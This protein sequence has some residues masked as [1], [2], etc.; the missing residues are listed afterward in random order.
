M[1]SLS[2]TSSQTLTAHDDGLH[3]HGVHLKEDNVVDWNRDA[4]DHPRNWK[5]WSKYY[6]VIVISWLELYMTG[7]SS[8]GVRSPAQYIYHI[9]MIY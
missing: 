8:A 3:A 6:T 5:P 1:A 9:T 2:E 4:R 7:I